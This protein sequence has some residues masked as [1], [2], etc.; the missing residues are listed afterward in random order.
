MKT[1]KAQKPKIIVMSVPN[2]PLLQLYI[3]RDKRGWFLT[4]SSWVA[5]NFYANPGDYSTK[6]CL[7]TDIA[8]RLAFS[9]IMGLQ[10][11][12]AKQPK[13]HTLF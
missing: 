9:R 2:T 7:P 3:C 1:K 10:E 6:F 8:R 11:R 4:Y 13:Q 5:F 12:V